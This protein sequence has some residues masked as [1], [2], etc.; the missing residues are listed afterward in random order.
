[1]KTWI[2]EPRDPLI[3]RDGRPFG[4]NSGIRAT[5]HAFPFPS[6][7]TGGVRTRA[8]LDS[9]GHF[10][11]SRID[12]VKK[13]AVQG[14]LLVQLNDEHEI[15]TWLPPAPA[16]ALLLEIDNRVERKQLVP[17]QLPQG[18]Q[19]DLPA[20][21]NLVG[22]RRPV[23]DKP[24]NKPLRYW[25]WREFEEWLLSPQERSI[26]TAELGQPGPIVEQRTHLRVNQAT[27]T[28]EEGLLFQTRGLTFTYWQKNI[29]PQRQADGNSISWG[30][31]KRLALVV[32]T[33][34]DIRAGLSAL[35]GE[36]RTVTWR[37]SDSALPEPPAGLIEH[38]AEQSACRLILLTSACFRD[39]YH[40][41]FLLQPQHG[42]I[43][44]VQGLALPRYQVVSGWDF[45]I[46]KPKPTRRLTP[47]GTVI[48]LKLDGDKTAIHQWANHFW[49]QT[50]ISD[51][52]QD[53]LDGF[54]LA[55]LG[56][57]SGKLETMKFSDHEVKS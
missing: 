9:K 53:R 42:V 38:I 34:G 20:G 37:K 10:D 31:A 36:R 29:E 39:G 2:I 12:D 46:N 19:T 4:P 56:T 17:L 23:P 18:A 14:P 25:Y 8:G 41:D 26:Q 49:L 54:G 43:P 51:A 28:A 1:M 50:C 22:M 21:L 44:H 24:L 40:P 6:T 47:A 57:W 27:Q 52:E 15:E 5:S 16:D 32:A 3:A 30:V 48:F 35:G 45:E 7:T 11:V 55:V 33:D 13:I